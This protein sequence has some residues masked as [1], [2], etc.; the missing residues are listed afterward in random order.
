MT[1]SVVNVFNGNAIA[2]MLSTDRRV[3]MS[4]DGRLGRKQSS[5][6]ASIIPHHLR[7][8]GA[9]ELVT[10]TRFGF[11]R[12]VIHRSVS[13][14]AIIIEGKGSFESITSGI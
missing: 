12:T 1:K 14:T 2:K 9:V 4:A 13:G 11:R 5:L 6:F 10:I 7:Q 3:N 8:T